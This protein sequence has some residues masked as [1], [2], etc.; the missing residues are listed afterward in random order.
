[1]KPALL[2][3]DVQNAFLPYMAEENKKLAPVIINMAVDLFRERGLPIYS[4]YHTDRQ[5]GPV[6]GSEG[7][8]YASSIKV[9]AD[10]TQVIKN[11]PNSFRETTL[12]SLLRKSDSDTV[13]LCGLSSTGCVLASYFGAKDLGFKAFLIKDALMGPHA[14]HTHCVEEIC[15]SVNLNVLQSMLEALEEVAQQQP[16]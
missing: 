7:F 11:Y 5:R 4:I 3:I 6:A 15:D 13:F 9:T 10:D 14:S 16:A 12:E 2:V 1:M 8:A